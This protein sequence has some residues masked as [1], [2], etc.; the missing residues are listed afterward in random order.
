MIL[1]V[2]FRTYLTAVQAKAAADEVTVTTLLGYPEEGRPLPTL[3]LLALTFAEDDFR[4][5]GRIRTLGRSEP[6]GNGIT[7]TLILLAEHEYGLLQLVDFV[8]GCKTHTTTTSLAVEGDQYQVS[9]SSTRRV[10]IGTND[11]LMHAA[12][13][14]VLFTLS[15]SS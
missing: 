2:L 13:I 15:L 9:Y 4:Q 8:R 12:E 1:S 6:Q 14:A 10:P 5:A 7:A 3:P 11:L